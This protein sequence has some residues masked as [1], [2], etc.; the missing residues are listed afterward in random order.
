MNTCG[1]A[2]AESRDIIPDRSLRLYP[3]MSDPFG[4]RVRLVECKGLATSGFRI[5]SVRES[6]F[7][8][9][10]LIEKWEWT[11]MRR[12]LRRKA[13]AVLGRLNFYSNEWEA[14]LLR[15]HD[16]DGFPI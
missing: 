10:A 14:F 15:L 9:S 3:R 4:Q 6:C 8:A 1:T 12:Q 11:N 16:S 13:F 7:D 2:H 5:E